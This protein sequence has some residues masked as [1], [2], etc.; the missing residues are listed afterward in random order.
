MTNVIDFKLDYAYVRNVVSSIDEL[1]RVPTEVE[2]QAFKFDTAR[3]QDAVV[4]PWYRD[5]DHPSFYYVAEVNAKFHGSGVFVFDI[6]IFSPIFRTV[7]ISV[8][9][10]NAIQVI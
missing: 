5:R 9:D 1:P 2:R 4:M 10:L 6:A 8:Y 7:V 3:F